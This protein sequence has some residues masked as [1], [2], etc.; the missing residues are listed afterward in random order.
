MFFTFNDCSFEEEEILKALNVVLI[1]AESAG[2]R[3]RTS[4]SDVSPS[5]NQKVMATGTDFC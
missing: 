3:P 4:F 2:S 1:A 5:L